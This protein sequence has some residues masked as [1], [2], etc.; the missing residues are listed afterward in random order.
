[1]LSNTTVF[2]EAFFVVPSSVVTFC[3]NISACS[4][5]NNAHFGYKIESVTDDLHRTC[6]FA[7]GDTLW[8]FFSSQENDI[9]LK[10]A[11]FC[12]FLERAF[13]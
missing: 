7:W 13:A 6:T 11:P 8:S 1:M 10:Q 4:F 12:S 3:N 9:T 5:S 2:V